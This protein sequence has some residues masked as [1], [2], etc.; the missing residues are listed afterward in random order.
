MAGQKH[1]LQIAAEL[2]ARGEIAQ[3]EQMYR[4]I[5]Q[6]RPGDPQVWHLLGV[7]AL[8]QGRNDEAVDLIG[9]AIAKDPKSAEYHNNLGIALD[10]LEQR[11]PAIDSFRRAIALR[12]LY[13]EAHN[14]LA[15][16][17]AAV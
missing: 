7:A 15:G 17:L 11:E 12:N 16:T 10:A 4:A 13:P 6:Q 3:A 5:L 8:Q 9:Q 1:P 2:H 14:N